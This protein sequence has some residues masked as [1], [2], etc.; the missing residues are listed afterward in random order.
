[1]L[2]PFFTRK[3]H[4]HSLAPRRYSPTPTSPSSISHCALRTRSDG[5]G[6]D[7]DDTHSPPATETEALG[8]TE[9]V[10]F[11]LRS[12]LIKGHD[13][14]IYISLRRQRPDAGSAL[15]LAAGRG[16]IVMCVY[17]DAMCSF[18]SCWSAGRCPDPLRR[19]E[20]EFSAPSDDFPNDR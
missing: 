14:C 11:S 4:A 20:C 16:G 1:M 8:C 17:F 9:N 10:R 12:L 2:S 5:D 18:P 13:A 15:A 7:R 3:S 19:R 6:D